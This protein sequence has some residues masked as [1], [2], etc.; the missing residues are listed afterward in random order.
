MTRNLGPL[1]A[2]VAWL[3]PTPGLTEEANTN[4]FRPAPTSHAVFTQDSPTLLARGELQGLVAFDAASALLVLRDPVTGA[5]VMDG[6]LV[7]RRLAMH[8]AF[9]YGLTSRL[10]LGAAWSTAVQTGD[11]SPYRADLRSAAVGDLLVRG[12]VALWRRGPLQVGAVLELSLPTATA[13]AHFGESGPS[14]S[15]QLLA[16]VELGRLSLS[17]RAGYHTRTSA[18]VADLELEDEV[19]TG[20]GASYAVVRDR[21]WAQLEGHGAW[22]LGAGDDEPTRPAELIAG[23]RIRVSGGWLAQA[24]LGFGVTRGYG[25]PAL[26]AILSLGRMPRAET[27]R[28]PAMTWTPSDDKQDDAAPP[29]APPP[30]E[31]EFI[32]DRLALPDSVLFDLGG[33]EVKDQGR[34]V[35]ARL[36]VLWRSHPEWEAMAIE[37]H[38]DLRGTARANQDLSER[39]ARNVRAAMIELGAR[40]EALTAVGHGETRPVVQAVTEAE[41]ARNRRVELVI[42]LRKVQEAAP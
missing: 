23:L 5:T 15:P 3:W 19:L 42:T 2:M 8:L 41:H 28:R 33:D 27:P 6:E 11:E 20:A 10:E 12:K 21:A 31:L 1:A 34:A 18:R 17:A 40:A 30:D 26:R 13:G 36:L 32:D 4:S 22:G 7:S 14:L 24:G 9:A 25:T 35:L 39:R 38:T 29:L 37:G 16:G